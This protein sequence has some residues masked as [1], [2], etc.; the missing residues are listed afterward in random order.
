[1]LS[2]RLVAILACLATGVLVYVDYAF[3]FS[4]EKM[5]FVIHNFLGGL[6]GFA[7]F[8]VGIRSKSKSKG[9]RFLFFASI[10]SGLA[11]VAIHATKL[12]LGKCI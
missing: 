11:M 8:F 3:F 2:K 9:D 4:G 7:L 10:V 12:F 1:M 6:M 5:A